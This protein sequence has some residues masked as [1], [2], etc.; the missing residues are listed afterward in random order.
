MPETI[1]QPVLDA[2]ALLAY[3]GNETG[4]EVVADSIAGGAT[5]CAVNLAE[6][7]STLA[8]RGSDPAGIVAD[9]TGR[10]LLDGAITIEPFTTADSR[11]GRPAA[12]GHPL[13]RSLV[14]R[15]RVP[16][17]CPPTISSGAYGP[18][19][20]DRPGAQHRCAIHS[21]PW[22]IA[23]AIS[24]RARLNSRSPSVTEQRGIR[25]DRLG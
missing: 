25:V 22:P 1:A 19:G 13:R 4:A 2:L 9:L 8:T 7:L 10:G 11:R 18:S 16:R 6:A 17:A 21:R 24:A 5:L 23:G 20:L 15:S 3:L 14:S 12:A